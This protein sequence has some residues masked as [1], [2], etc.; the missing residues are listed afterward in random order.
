MTQRKNNHGFK[1]LPLVLAVAGCLFSTT[2]M[3]QSEAGSEPK[4][5]KAQEEKAKET[6]TLEKITVTGS[7]IKRLEYDSVSPVQIITADTNV[8]LGQIET[9]E[10]LQK[11]SIA[12]GATQISHQFGAFVTEGGVG[13]QTL[14]LRGLGANRSLVLLNGH[15]PGP[16]GTRGQVG[17]FDLNVLPSSIVQRVELLKDGS[18]SIYGSDAVAGVANVITR[19]NID[20]P[21]ISVAFRAPFY[22]GGEVFSISG[23]NGWN[24]DNGSIVLAG[25]YYKQEPLKIGDRDFFKCAEDLVWDADGNRIDRQDRSIIAGTALGNCSSG[26][27]YANTVIDALTGVRYV[28][29]W[30]GTT[31]GNLPGYRPRVSTTYLNSPQ[32]SYTDVLNYPFIGDGYVIQD[33]ERYSAY[34]AAD[35]TFGDI[36]WNTEFLYNRRESKYEG[37]RQFFPLI[38]G[39]PNPSSPYYYANDPDFVNTAVPSGVAQPIMPFRSSS[40]QQVDYFYVNSNL[41]GLF[42]DTWSWDING[43]YSRSSGKYSN[44]A[45]DAS[46]T[47]DW[48]YG[49]DAPT[50]N[51]F[52]PG[53]LSG[54]RMDE[55]VGLI[56]AWDTGKTV[57]DQFV[58]TGVIT[59]EL[60]SLPAGAVGAALG[61]E[62]REFSIDDQPGPLSQAGS[63]WGSS[64]AQSTVGDDSVKEVFAEVEVPLLKGLPGVESLV[65]NASTRWFDYDSV[66]DSDTVWKVGLG[67]QIVPALRLRATRG[68]SYRAPG[69]YELY[70]GN[71]SGFLSQLQVDPCIQWGDSSN[72]FLRANCAA[73]GLPE[74]FTGGTSSATVYQGGGAGFLTPEHSEAFTTGLIWTPEFA[75]ISVAL[76]YFEITVRDQIGE[77]GANTIVSSCYGAEVYPNSFCDMFTRNP[78]T[79]PSNANGIEEIFATYVNINKQKVSGFDLLV[80]YEDDFS[81]GQLTVE[82]QFTYT[83]EDVTQLFDSPLAGGSTISDYAGGIGRPKLVGNIVTSL[84]RGDW[85]Y[86]WGMDYV[87]ETKRLTPVSSTGSYT[88]FGHANAVVD[89][90]ADSRLYHSFSVNYD[91]PKWSMLLGV[92]NLLNEKPD[93]V[94]AAA[95]YSRYGNVPV[96]ATQYD[97]LGVSLFARLN[98]KF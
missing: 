42:A 54:A 15:R 84:E 95:G 94:S 53:F 67:W 18:S 10:F 75:P 69:L 2:A 31:I 73:A 93:T 20:S 34:A 96:D 64:S 12:A 87:D 81:F 97:Y 92:R 83:K 60:F 35:F 4:E 88:Y 9:S 33:L 74:T 7:L 57:Y 49:E 62:Y 39:S 11:S 32:A 91:Q 37:F 65:F 85:T 28:P 79:A 82:S 26:N 21:E 5:E 80:R 46:K 70:L 72:A 77:L 68:T 66:N 59:G 89:T 29:S 8:A 19:K 44:L 27:L 36:N 23:A 41:N 17:A 56:G 14:S 76:D 50:I 1:R 52:D 78:A 98:Y 3:A 25:E 47:G 13:A 22:G 71:Q 45:I 90:T 61:A 86:T 38:V 16:A 48:N 58:F 6:T 30:D 24:F 63:L 51:Y 43:S 55:L 40:Q